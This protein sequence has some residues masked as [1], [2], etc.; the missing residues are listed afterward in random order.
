MSDA[1][2]SADDAIDTPTWITDRLVEKIL[3]ILNA[4]SEKEHTKR[5]VVEL[6]LHSKQI[7]HAMGLLGGDEQ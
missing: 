6:L 3:S 7:M 5:E 4:D 2:N 1:P